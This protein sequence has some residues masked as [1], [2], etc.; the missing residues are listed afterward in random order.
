MRTFGARF[1]DWRRGA[2]QVDLDNFG[3]ARAHEKQQL[4]LGPARQKLIDDA[5]Q[6]LVDVGDAGKIALVQNCRREARLGKDHH[7][8]RRLDEVSA[9]SRSHDKKKRILDFTME[10]NDACKSAENFALPAFLDD[11]L[12]TAS[13]DR[14]NPFVVEWRER[15]HCAPLRCGYPEGPAIAPCD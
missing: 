6:F 10:P 9:G 12:R 1:W 3:R 14:N 2:F 15:V 7:A 13:R 5:I 11:L 8:R 4:D